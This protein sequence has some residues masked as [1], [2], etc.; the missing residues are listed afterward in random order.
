MQLVE[1]RNLPNHVA[2]IM[3]GNGRWAELRGEKRSAGHRAGS[4]AVRR[5]VRLCRRLGIDALTLYAFSFQNWERPEDEVEALMQLLGEYLINEREEILTRGI[6]L[7][8]IGQLER[9]AMRPGGASAR[10]T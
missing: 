7:A 5:T 2:I 9:H 1:A 10:T 4:H 3:D 8:A 6:R